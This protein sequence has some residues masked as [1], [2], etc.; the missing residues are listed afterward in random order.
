MGRPTR[1]NLDG[2][3]K[4][5]SYTSDAAVLP[6]TALVLDGEK[7]KV[8]AAAD[9]GAKQVYVANTAHLQGL[10]PVDEIPAG[11]TIEGEYFDHHRRMAVRVKAGESLVKDTPL[12]LGAGG[13]FEIAGDGAVAAFSQEIITVPETG[14]QLVFVQ[15]AN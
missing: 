6:G 12:S 15:V 3:S 2:L 1:V 13:V 5:E 9:I 8:A 4:T 11:D 7:F 10:G 14:N